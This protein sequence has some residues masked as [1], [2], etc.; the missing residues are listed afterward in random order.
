M[1]SCL[2]LKKHDKKE[3]YIAYLIDKHVFFE[4]KTVKRE[5]YCLFI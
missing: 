1:M 4:L 2:S 3:K 5:I